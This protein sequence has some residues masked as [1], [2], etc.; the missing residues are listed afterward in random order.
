MEEREDILVVTASIEPNG[1]GGWYIKAV[2]TETDEVRNCNT[3]QEYSDFLTESVYQ[4]EKENFK[5]VWLE[6]P[7][8]TK[9]MIEDVRYKLVKFH[10]DMESMGSE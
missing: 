2:N 6:S 9:E 7:N 10:E 4:T 5:A 8:A 1:L 3:I